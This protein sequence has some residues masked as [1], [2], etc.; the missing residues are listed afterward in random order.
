M[1]QKESW[2]FT[3]SQPVRL[4]QGEQKEREGMGEG[5]EGSDGCSGCGDD[6][7]GCVN[8]NVCITE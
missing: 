2:C 1:V 8:E 5:D 6:G 7:G 4:Y 3:P